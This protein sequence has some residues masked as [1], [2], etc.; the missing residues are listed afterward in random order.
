MAG[1]LKDMSKIKQ[2]IQLHLNGKSNRKIA[3]LLEMNKETVNRYVKRI[4]EDTKTPKEL[5]GLDNP[6]LEYRLTGGSPAYTDERFEAFK[7]KLP[8]YQQEMCRKHVTA[9]LLWEEYIEENPEGYSLT[10]FRYHFKQNT[11]AQK[12]PSTVLKDKYIPGEKLY[13]DFAG[14]TLSYCDVS[15]GEIIECQVFVASMP[16][17]DYGYALAVPSQKSEDFVY[18]VSQCLKSLGGVPSIL[19]PDNLK[20]AVVK[21]GKYEPTINKIFDDLCNHYHCVAIPARPLRPKDKCLVEDQ[22]KL[23]Y[24]RVY[25]PLRNVMFYSSED[26]NAAIAQKMK[27]HNQKRL[28]GQPYSRE[29]QFLALEKPALKPLPEEDFEIQSYTSLKV[30]PNGCIYLGR[31][32]HQYSVPYQYIGQRTE[33]I[34]TRTMVNVYIDGK[35]I[36][37]HKRDY[38]HGGYTYVEEHLASACR[39]YRE[40]SP[41][42]Y[43]ERGYKALTI[44][45]DVVK[46]MFDTPK[47]PPEIFYKGCDGLFHLQKTTDPNVFRMACG[48]AVQY[49]KCSYGFISRLVHSKCAGYIHE[50]ERSSQTELTAPP[51]N[52]TNIRGKSEYQ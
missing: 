19:V 12:T 13:L 43:I 30:S 51:A 5:L 33:V 7:L 36:A 31:D 28:T 21:T 10:Q 2:L 26:L 3:E 47:A 8:Y 25:A 48:I 32:Y 6:I 14:D 18:A 37:S 41:Q 17:T 38:K 52:H 34:Y 50:M 46:R 24:R 9:K 4:T 29:E 1:K 16:A 44:L 11:V 39:A 42:Y 35:R 22:V 45:G 40:R 20:A 23:L 49:D 15:T 27:E